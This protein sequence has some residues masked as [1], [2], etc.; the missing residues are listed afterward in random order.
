MYFIS[1]HFGQKN[2][3]QREN[4]FDW[5]LGPPCYDPHVTTVFVGLHWALNGGGW[6]CHI[7]VHLTWL[8]VCN[9]QP[10]PAH[11]AKKYVTLLRAREEKVEEASPPVEVKQ[12]E[13]EQRWSRGSRYLETNQRCQV[14]SAVLCISNQQSMAEILH[15]WLLSMVFFLRRFGLSVNHGLSPPGGVR[16]CGEP[17]RSRVRH[18]LRESLA[19]CKTFGLPTFHPVTGTR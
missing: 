3:N 13:Q 12:V 9:T 11:S 17:T 6:F 5:V 1:C 10:K 8:G 14:L 15:S 4:G 16:P 18:I 7:M 19:L 2:P